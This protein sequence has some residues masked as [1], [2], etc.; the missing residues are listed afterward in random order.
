MNKE[1][2]KEYIKCPQFGDL[3]YGKWGTL[4]LEQRVAF[5]DLIS[6][7]ED[8]DKIIEGMYRNNDS[9]IKLL[10]KVKELNKIIDKQEELIENLKCEISDL[11]DKTKDLENSEEFD[12]YSEY[13]VSER[14]FY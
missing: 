10:N 12:P 11:K 3:E 1:K 13:G 7:I 9:A 14:D 8:Q 6:L 5:R 2:I 4:T